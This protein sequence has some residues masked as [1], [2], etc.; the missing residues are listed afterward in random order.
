MPKNGSRDEWVARYERSR[1]HPVNRVCHTL[2]IPMVVVSLLLGLVSIG[3]E[4][5]RIPALSLFVP[6]WML[7]L[8][9]HAFEGKPR[10]FFRDWRFL[11][12]GFPGGS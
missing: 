2:G 4:G 12:V 8:V 6:G 1:Q 10:E 9:G 5:L 3:V 11:L 7:Q